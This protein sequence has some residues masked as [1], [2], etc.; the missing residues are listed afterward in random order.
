MIG[1]TFGKYRI[2]ERLG[3]GGMGTVYR[4]IDESLD[5]DV[6]IKVLNPDLADSDVVR[7]FRAE[8]TTLAKLNH[9]GI[10]TIFELYRDEQDLLLVMEFVRGESLDKLAERWGPLAPEVAAQ[11]A[12]QIL[13][14]LAYA[15]RAGVVHRDLKPANLMVTEFGGVKILDFGIARVLGSEHMTSD[16]VMMGTPAYMA[17]EQILGDDVDGRADLYAVGVILYRLLTGK[18]P[19]RA[20]TA[21][22]MVQKQLKDPPTPLRQFRTELPA[23]C[24]QVL[25]RALSKSPADRFPTAEA[26]RTAIVTTCAGIASGPIPVPPRADETALETTLPPDTPLK[27]DA[28]MAETLPLSTPAPP[29]IPY[30]P[31]SATGTPVAAPSPSAAAA[32]QSATVVLK[33]QHV[34][35]GIATICLVVIVAAAGVAVFVGRR[36][37]T[38]PAPPAASAP[39]TAA[40]AGGAAP[41]TG[42][43][44]P[45][46][47]SPSPAAAGPAAASSSVP[48]KEPA[49][50][51]AAAGAPAAAP[52]SGPATVSAPA[53]DRAA[54]AATGTPGAR[55]RRSTP[56]TADAPAAPESAA[57]PPVTFAGVKELFTERNTA[58]ELDADLT[59]TPTGITSSLKNGAEEVVLYADV[60]SVAYSHSRN[61]LWSSPGG[62]APV[63]RTGGGGFPLFGRGDRHWLTIRTAKRFFVFRLRPEQVNRLATA[64]AERSGRNVERLEEK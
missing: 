42:R 6:A 13:D 23:W 16:G 24:G 7:R 18:L 14:P 8:A 56:A 41:A 25:D 52:A 17:P 63:M 11:V 55:P 45:Q 47:P 5:R 1:R 49:A 9:P 19:F 27:Q 38:A 15:H 31:A 3:R 54:A 29:P 53:P 33:R 61:P 26:F 50:P 12:I 30:T 57:L 62:P 58:R 35:A 34:F 46:A 4:A 37:A 2:V 32:P 20:D 64:I 28:P 21:I 10:A 44:S 48:A 59:L 22:A 39:T 60:L 40:P 36:M 51:R 43:G